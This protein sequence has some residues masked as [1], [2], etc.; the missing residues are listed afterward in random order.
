MPFEPNKTQQ[1]VM[2]RLERGLP[3]LAD[4]SEPVAP[5]RVT[6]TSWGREGTTVVYH[7]FLAGLLCPEMYRVYAD[8][9]V[10]RH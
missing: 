6:S 2:R 7:R 3:P 4:V 9:R 10:S 5:A 8:G 1:Q